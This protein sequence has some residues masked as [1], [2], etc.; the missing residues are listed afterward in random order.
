[1]SVSSLAPSIEER[2]Q[3]DLRT[4]HEAIGLFYRPGKS[5]G[6]LSA[7]MVTQWQ[8]GA[9]LHPRNPGNVAIKEKV[10]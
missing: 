10:T 7:Y 6:V 1:M 9:T 4:S 8:A 2:F 3:A 5:V